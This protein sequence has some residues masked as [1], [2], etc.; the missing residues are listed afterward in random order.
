MKM[1][2]DVKEIKLFQFYEWGNDTY[3]IDYIFPYKYAKS[4]WDEEDG[5]KSLDVCIT[6]RNK[7]N[8][9]G[10]W[11]SPKSWRKSEEVPRKA[12]HKF[13]ETVFTK[14]EEEE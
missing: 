9:F 13:I 2:Y 11:G 10:E 14:E 5:V 8:F 4:E 12:K 7:H 6:P 3:R 1:I